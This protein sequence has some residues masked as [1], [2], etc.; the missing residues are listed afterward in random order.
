MS[1]NIRPVGRLLVTGVPGWLTDA[2]LDSLRREPP[3]GLTAVRCLVQPGPGPAAVAWD[4]TPFPMERVTAD[5]RD[6]A[7]LAAA[8]RG[9]D[10]VLHAAGVL[11]VGR[12]RDWY[13]VNTRG[14]MRLL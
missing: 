8:A 6:A 5:L 4:E 1:L 12:T 13:D 2:L 11:H 10:T 7:S 14:T 9:V 3:A